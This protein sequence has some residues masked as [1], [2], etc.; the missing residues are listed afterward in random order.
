MVTQLGGKKRHGAQNVQGD[1]G[2]GLRGL[3]WNLESEEILNGKLAPN[4]KIG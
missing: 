3:N 4:V 1:T 2:P